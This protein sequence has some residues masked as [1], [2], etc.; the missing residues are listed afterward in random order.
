MKSCNAARFVLTNAA[1]YRRRQKQQ[2]EHRRIT[3]RNESEL[4]T[5]ISRDRDFAFDSGVDV[6]NIG[7]RQSVEYRRIGRKSESIFCFSDL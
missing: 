5:H 7:D 3:L 2:D 4:L 1:N 6:A